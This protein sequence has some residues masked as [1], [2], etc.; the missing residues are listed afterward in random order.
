M[1]LK[2]QLYGKI[3]S[4]KKLINVILLSLGTIRFFSFSV[5]QSSSEL[6]FEIIAA[7]T[8]EQAKPGQRRPFI[9]L[10]NWKIGSSF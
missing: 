8:G 2:N 3:N 9:M 1:T 10:G 5:A 6:T 7:G 4:M